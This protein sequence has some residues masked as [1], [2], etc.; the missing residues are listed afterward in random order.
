[1]PFIRVLIVSLPMLMAAKPLKVIIMAGQSNM[2]GHGFVDHHAS[3]VP[4]SNPGTLE[5]LVKSN[6]KE[7]EAQER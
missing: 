4:A 2:Q 5:Q 3:K 6:P 1:M 7:Y